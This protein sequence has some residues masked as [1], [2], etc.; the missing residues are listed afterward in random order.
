MPPCW[1][2]CHSTAKVGPSRAGALLVAQ[3]HMV[4]HALRGGSSRGTLSAVRCA[5]TSEG[6][7]GWHYQLVSWC[8]RCILCCVPEVPNRWVVCW[9]H[10][11]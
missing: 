4:W 9:H 8:P 1:H 3:V 5:V 10:C 7:G 2:G 11:L 6:G